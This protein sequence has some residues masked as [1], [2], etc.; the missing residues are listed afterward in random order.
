MIC[1]AY[2]VVATMAHALCFAQWSPVNRGVFEKIAQV[3]EQIHRANQANT[4]V[5]KKTTATL[6]ATRI[7]RMYRAVPDWSVVLRLLSKMLGDDVVLGH[8]LLKSA[9]T[10]AK[11]DT[12]L[13]GNNEP[14]VI[15]DLKGFARSQAAISQFA[16]RLEQTKLFD[17]VVVLETKREPFN[18][19]DAVA[20][21]MK[22]TIASGTDS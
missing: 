20:F 14:I 15:L 12:A 11:G 3:S 2:G 10:T 9:A 19:A 16:I 21:T 22:C 7:S 18:S 4:A 1:L 8:C 5:R 6:E 13:P 17:Q